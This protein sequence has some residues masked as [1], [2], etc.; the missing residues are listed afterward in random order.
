M[1]SCIGS[2]YF[3][4]RR[5]WSCYKMIAYVYCTHL[6]T[7]CY[8]ENLI[9]CIPTNSTIHNVVTIW[10]VVVL[11]VFYWA[12]PVAW[13]ITNATLFINV[14]SLNKQIRKQF[15]LPKHIA[16]DPFFLFVACRQVLDTHSAT[17]LWAPFWDSPHNSFCHWICATALKCKR[18]LS[19]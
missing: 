14:N 12:S 6:P 4:S 18:T 13:I 3:P 11:S 15:F 9:L 16:F 5:R 1:S 7:D 17:A 19:H 2:K 8:W 10:K